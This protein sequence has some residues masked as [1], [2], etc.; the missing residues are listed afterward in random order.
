MPVDL[1]PVSA[2][3]IIAVIGGVV[4]VAKRAGLPSQWAGILSLV[5]GVGFG[6]VSFFTSGPELIN[7]VV[8]GAVLGLTATGAYAAAAAAAGPALARR[9]DRQPPAG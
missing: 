5:V 7:A 8:N 4:E 6:I 9:N 1:F 2:V 3:V